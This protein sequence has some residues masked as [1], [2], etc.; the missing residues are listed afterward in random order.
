MRVGKSSL[1]DIKTAPASRCGRRLSPGAAGAP[2]SLLVLLIPH[3]SFVILTQEVITA[4]NPRT[5]APAIIV[6]TCDVVI[7]NYI[8]YLIFNRIKKEADSGGYR[9]AAATMRPPLSAAIIDSPK[10]AAVIVK[11]SGQP[12]KLNF[13]RI[14]L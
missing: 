4:I 14:R 2:Q 1:L 8:G 3:R 9:P 10:D 6:S 12:P 11:A 7:S 13:N 5:A